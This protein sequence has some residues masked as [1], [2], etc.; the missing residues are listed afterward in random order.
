MKQKC[1][2]RKPLLLLLAVLLLP[3]QPLCYAEE[4]AEEEIPVEEELVVEEEPFEPEELVI[5]EAEEA[6]REEEF[7]TLTFVCNDGTG[8]IFEVQVPVDEV[9]VEPEAPEWEGHLF[10]GWYNDPEVG[11]KFS[12]GELLYMD[13]T[14]YA[15]WSVNDWK[16]SGWFPEL[17]RGGSNIAYDAESKTLAFGAGELI[18]NPYGGE[19]AGVEGSNAVYSLGFRIAA[20]SS[21]T[22]DGEIW[23]IQ[24]GGIWQD[25]N[26]PEGIWTGKENGCLVLDVYE[27]LDLTAIK[28]LA[29]QNA[30]NYKE[31]SHPG[32]RDDLTIEEEEESS[33]G[34]RGG[35][36]TRDGESFTPILMSWSYSLAKAGEEETSDTA[37]TVTLDPRFMQFRDGQDLAFAI[38]GYYYRYR[39]KFNPVDGTDDK[40]LPS[41][42]IIFGNRASEP[43]PAPEKNGFVFNGWY[44]GWKDKNTG[45]VFYSEWPYNFDERIRSSFTLY[46]K[47]AEVAFQTTLNMADFTG[48]YVYV[49]LPEGEDASDY[50]IEAQGASYRQD[51]TKPPVALDSLPRGSGA[52]AGM[53]RFEILRAGSPEMTDEVTV[54]LKKGDTT[55]RTETYSVYTV[56]EAMLE[57][58]GLTEDQES[59]L[60]SLLQYGYYGHIIFQN[61]LEFNPEI[62]NAPELVPIPGDY[63]PQGDPPDFGM[64][65]TGFVEKLNL[66]SVIAMNL[67]LTLADGY[68]MNDFSCR[69]LDRDGNVYHNCSVTK[70]G[71][72]GLKVSIRGIKSPQMARDFRLVVTLKSDPTKTATW[73]RSVW[74]CAYEGSART[75]DAGR[76]FLQA[77]YQYGLYAQRQ[78]PSAA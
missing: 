50:T 49:G 51:F 31:P 44:N 63:A 48:V 65:V 76:S 73:T 16:I 24:L 37:L 29:D 36:E 7:H 58:G 42:V 41:Q 46:A 13:R 3:A 55:V 26:G 5:E 15:H 6:I 18:L 43:S 74:A 35:G 1:M 60:K 77:L 10:E 68:S 57:K 52:R 9:T 71:D 38:T 62:E 69:V 28:K 70:D 66:D 67:Y 47:W 72:H 61:P 11:R 53:F 8:E 75:T 59:L 27:P 25:F 40:D 2:T 54:I 30:R 34:R 19:S 17:V 33:G 39:V 14:L 64:Y 22:E 12:F 32:T 20:P 45:E 21:V 23:R 56:A 4:P 78:F